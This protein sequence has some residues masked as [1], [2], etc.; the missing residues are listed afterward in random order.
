MI[1]TAKV[2]NPG[3]R[4]YLFTYGS[5]L[6][7]D[8]IEFLLNR[9]P[10]QIQNRLMGFASTQIQIGDRNFPTL[11]E[12]KST[13]FADG[14]VT[15]INSSELNSIDNHFSYANRHSRVLVKLANEIEAWTYIVSN[16]SPEETVKILE[17]EACGIDDDMPMEHI[18]QQLAGLVM[19]LEITSES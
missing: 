17:E 6:P 19:G 2:R 16:I 9:K 11:I 3:Q 12:T 18:A 1:P 4:K 13:N 5:L 10:V 14:F 15:K 7:P 8:I